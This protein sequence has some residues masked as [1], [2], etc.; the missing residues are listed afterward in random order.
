M[1]HSDGFWASLES[2]PGLADVDMAWQ[3]SMGTDYGLGKTFL[4]P[5]GRLGS[6]YPCI[7]RAFCACGA[8]DVIDHGDGRIVAVC[9]CGKG[10]KTYKLT[11]ADIVVYEVDEGKLDQTIR[12]ALGLTGES[13][14]MEG[15]WGVRQIGA[16]EPCAGFRFPVYLVIVME[17]VQFQASV[18]AIMART[19]GSF[20]LLEPTRDHC[21]PGIE[22]RLRNRKSLFV[23]LE[24]VLALGPVGNFQLKLYPDEI[25]GDFPARNVP[26]P[27][28]EP[29]TSF[30][31]T[32]VGTTWGEV[33]IRFVD[34]HSVSV[35]ARSEGG[36]FN[37]T[38]MGMA[39]RRNGEPTTQWEMLRV[40][41][42]E[43]GVLDWSSRGADPRNKKRR[44]LLAGRL[45][46]FFRIEEEP[47]CLTGD[48][49]GWQ[50][51]FE[52]RVDG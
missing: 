5:N 26:K 39:S 49:K 30:F 7:E 40:F 47:F 43:H 15:M 24:E 14:A 10:C 12:E 3:M 37:Y 50:S 11:H 25:L 2:V 17:G 19:E 32:P 35:K 27:S 16:Y 38:Q 9:K 18:D 45:R 6:G 31:P 33:S 4:R 41:A 28:A 34:G 23:P 1:S 20:I 51:R 46:E 29:V 36:V 52:I 48:G 8:H 22:E 42:E 13:R 21:T 44:I